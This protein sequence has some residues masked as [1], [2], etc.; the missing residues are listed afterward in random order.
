MSGIDK[1]VEKIISDAEKQRG[2]I[3]ADAEKKARELTE[4]QLASAQ[5]QCDEILA[6][7]KRDA[8]NAESLAA[9]GGEQ[10]YRRSM[11]AVK[12]DILDG[13]LDDTLK[14]ML[15]LEDDKYFEVLGGLIRAN[16]HKG[17][18]GVLR[19][20]AKD[21]A[22]LP[23]DFIASLKADTGAGFELSPEAVDI[24]GGVILVYGDIEENLSFEAL[25]S[26]RSDELRDIASALLF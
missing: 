24:S 10:K 20:N 1:I 21:S 15:A 11:L 18:D 26:S 8:D 3:I 16:A 9:V 5:A 14:A 4:S 19:L 6:Q 7:A 23:K 17:E 13:I 25:V 22:R 2:Q 12:I